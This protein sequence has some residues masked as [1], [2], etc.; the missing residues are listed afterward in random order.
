MSR[1]NW[2]K[3]HCWTGLFFAW[4]G[5]AVC[6]VVLSLKG[7][8]FVIFRYRWLDIMLVVVGGLTIGIGML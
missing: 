7:L 3:V 2:R 8:F 5:I 4:D 1:R 6:L